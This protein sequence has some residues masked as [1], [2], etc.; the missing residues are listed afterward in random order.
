MAAPVQD[1]GPRRLPEIRA[2]LAAWLADP[3]PAGGPTVWAEGF[4][5]PTA[6]RE[7]A[8][9]RRWAAS[10]RAADLFFI[11]ADMSRLAVS[12][13]LALPS[14]RMH[15][16][17]LPAP[18]GL[19]MWEEP[20]TEGHSGGE[21]TGAPIIAATW[22]VR[23]SGITVRTWAR[24]EDWIRF[25]AEGDDRAG[26][27]A[28]TPDQVRHVRLRYPQP[29]VAMSETT[30]PFGERPG[31]LT[32]PPPEGT[33]LYELED[34]AKTWVRLEQ[35]ERALVVTWLL[36]GQTLATS[37]EVEPTRASLKF[38][39]RLDPGL[40]ATTR[41]V[42]LR[43][44]STV[45]EARAAADGATPGRTYQH[46]W[47]VRGHWRNAWYPSRQDHR[48]VW[49]DP[50]LKGPDGAPILDPTKLVSVLKR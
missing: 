18:H 29:I 50:H 44:R 41:Y 32:G 26:I 14:Y 34:Q 22:A 40:L 9:A 3:S 6:A 43:H 45:P 47:Y 7:R 2:E 4:D 49:I 39:R 48:P 36:M 8:S 15:P 17:D 21:I 37:A 35:A 16:E 20:V 27:R 30:M 25:M 38:I 23:G 33:S 13:G 28:L 12:A 1:L 11:A 19:V 31:W 46:R 5:A 10:L 42:Q 24:R